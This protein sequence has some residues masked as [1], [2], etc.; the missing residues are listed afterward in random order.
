MTIDVLQINADGSQEIVSKELP[1]DWNV[2]LPP[3]PPSLSD[4]VAA[5]NAAVAELMGV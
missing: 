4:Q 1:D 5:L 3:A 2:P